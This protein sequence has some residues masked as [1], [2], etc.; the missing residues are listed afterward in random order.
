MVANSKFA[1]FLFIHHSPIKIEMQLVF[2]KL[3]IFVG[4]LPI[5]NAF[6]AQ[7]MSAHLFSPLEKIP[8][9]AWLQ[10]HSAAG[11]VHVKSWKVLRDERI[12]KQD[13]DY[14]C[15]AASLATLLTAHY[16]ISVSEEALLQ[17]MDKGDARAS[18]EDMARALAQFGFKAQGFAAS[19]EQLIK[20]RV[21]VVVYLKHRKNDHF[22]ALCGI[23]ENT[24]WLVDPSLGNRTC[25][26]AQFL[27]M[28][29]TREDGAERSDLR[30][31]FLVVLPHSSADTTVQIAT[32]FFSKQPRR[33]SSAGVAQLGIRGF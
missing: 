7:E 11:R 21:P 25:S 15:G 33:Q 6:S 24:V 22:Y 19:W 17:V 27:A 9:S 20:L 16:G 13:L 3:C 2:C 10:T 5:C 14:S 18:F 4:M 23:D 31:K 28:W 26:K 8:D 30:G 12:V 32:N 1:T 29:Q